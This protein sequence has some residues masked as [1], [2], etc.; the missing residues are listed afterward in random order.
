MELKVK[1][2]CSFMRGLS[3]HSNI[4]IYNNYDDTKLF[5]EK[6][7]QEFL[8]SIEKLI[9][10]F[11]RP[12]V[13]LR[14][15]NENNEIINIGTQK[16]HF[17]S[18]TYLKQNNHNYYIFI[19]SKRNLS[20]IYNKKP[21]LNY[22]YNKDAVY[23][24]SSVDNGTVNLNFEFSVKYFKP[25]TLKASIVVRKTK[26]S[27]SFNVN[28][29]VVSEL[30]SNKYKIR[31][32][33]RLDIE[34][35]QLL[36]GEN[37]D[38]SN[39]DFHV[40][41]VFFHFEVNELPLTDLTPK[42]AFNKSEEKIYND[43]NWINYDN[44]NMLLVRF[45]RTFHGYLSFKLSVIPKETYHYYRQNVILNH[46][47]IKKSKP[48]IVCIEYPSSAQDNGLAFFEYLLKNYS[49]KYN[50]Y[51]VIHKNSADLD[52]L[53]QY[54]DN[55][56]FYKT[57]ENL[58]VLYEADI[59][60]H[61]HT[62]YYILP[63]RV[64]ELEREL[65]T[66]KRV[67][68]QHGI[69]GVR[70]L[71]YMYGRKKHERFTDLFVVSSSREKKIITNNYGFSPNEVILT[72]LP[73]F[74]LLIEESKNNKLNINQKKKVLIMPTWRPG[75][76]NLSDEEFKKTNYYKTFTSLIN[77]ESIKK[78]ANLND[79]E[80]M[81]FMHRNFQKYNHLFKSNFVKILS[82]I[83]HNIKDLLYDSSLLITDY[84]SVALDFA[85]MRRKVIYY[86]PDTI[87]ETSLNPS[88]TMEL[89]GIIVENEQKL[90]EELKNF[91]F[92]SG[93]KLSSIYK[94]NDTKACRRIFKK[95]KKQFKL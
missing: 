66:K 93:I 38:I 18:N 64:N 37:N 68:L 41:D 61:T 11:T 47:P 34:D 75:L 46:K 36:I 28:N 12:K 21:S 8:L 95:M 58:K 31:A 23:K 30:T 22:F 86:Q 50:I 53:K 42:I 56:I 63:F 82:D 87:M 15:Y 74:D 83:D 32:S 71:R 73:R 57:A 33:L 88:S 45:Y 81:I 79:V 60:C 20:L 77:N 19:D 92:D 5:F 35:I 2:N 78:L 29:F 84:S 65:A 10:F 59:I 62:S 27:K 39:Y 54:K 51:Y 67:F 43:E 6:N 70:D 49:N 44:N 89:P 48:T 40:Y 17:E 80:F 52:N 16:V 4:Y 91:R 90:L 1:K 7:D 25:T 26:E 9:S 76:D 24:G 55:V 3:N 14:L 72:G 13:V 69:I 85:I 94:F